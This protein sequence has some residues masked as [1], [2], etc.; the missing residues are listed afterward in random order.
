MMG[1]RMPETCGTVFKRQ[2]INLRNYCSWLVDSFEC[3]VIY[4]TIPC[5]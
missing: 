2:V 3:C 5:G 1:M 4:L